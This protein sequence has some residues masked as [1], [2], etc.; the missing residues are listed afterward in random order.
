[1]DVTAGESSTPENSLIIGS[2]RSRI[3]KTGD[4]DMPGYPFRLLMVLFS[5]IMCSCNSNYSSNNNNSSNNSS[6]SSSNNRITCTY[7]PLIIVPPV[8]QRLLRMEWCK[9]DFASP[10]IFSNGVSSFIFRSIFLSDCQLYSFLHYFN[11]FIA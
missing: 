1:M 5:E 3:K 11:L 8:F 4:L 2:S 7:L 10:P 9:M 6:S